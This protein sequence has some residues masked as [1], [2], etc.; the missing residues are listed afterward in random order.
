MLGNCARIRSGSTF[1]TVDVTRSGSTFSTADVT[2]SWKMSTCTVAVDEAVDF[3]LNGDAGEAR[4]LGGRGYVWSWS[5]R[6]GKGESGVKLVRAVDCVLAI[7]QYFVR[8]EDLPFLER[9]PDTRAYGGGASSTVSPMGGGAPATASSIEGKASGSG[10]LVQLRID[11]SASRYKR[12]NSG[13]AGTP[14]SWREPS[15]A[16]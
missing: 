14:A 6:F 9:L 10:S 3:A 1:S 7:C 2:R 11:Q 16:L 8:L 15:M 13:M 5:R 12:V 4:S